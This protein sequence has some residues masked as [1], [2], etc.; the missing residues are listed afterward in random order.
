MKRLATL[1]TEKSK[2]TP[3]N[4]TLQ[5]TKII[6]TAPSPNLLQVIMLLH[7]A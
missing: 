4:G 2:G 1:G 7:D 3:T 6:F 5:D